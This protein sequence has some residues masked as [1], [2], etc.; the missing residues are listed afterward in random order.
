M[1][2]AS[3]RYTWKANN[4]YGDNHRRLTIRR[5]KGGE[6]F[7]LDV[8]HSAGPQ[9]SNGS[10]I[11]GRV[12]KIDD[13]RFTLAAETDESWVHDDDNWSEKRPSTARMEL[14]IREDANG[15]VI[16][17]DG[18]PWARTPKTLFHADDA[19]DIA[20]R[21]DTL[22]ASTQRQWGKMD[23]AQML[24]H[25]HRAL[26][27]ATGELK[28]KRTL[29]GFLFGRLAK[30]KLLSEKPWSHNLPTDPR[31]V[32]DDARDFRTEKIALLTTIWRFAQA[33]TAGISRDGHPFFG[34]L[35]PEEWGILMYRHLDHHLCQFGA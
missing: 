1:I 22:T 10:T 5:G 26:K 25:V 6:S 32:V 8:I 23:V 27:T 21:I 20:A 17:L 4:A 24:T 18:E 3:G 29:I 30:R 34:R 15:L 35:T 12:E 7:E 28:L 13:G 9:G 14:V 19:G 16:E 31:F 11:R 2:R 33:G